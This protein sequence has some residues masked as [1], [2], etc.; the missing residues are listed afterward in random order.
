MLY[1]YTDNNCPK[2]VTLKAIYKSKGITYEER[3]AERVKTP[4][5]DTDREALIEGSLNNM[6]LPI[7]VEWPVVGILPGFAGPFPTSH[8]LS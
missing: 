7:V 2:C 6:E 8:G 4:Q 3:D 1:I 5:D